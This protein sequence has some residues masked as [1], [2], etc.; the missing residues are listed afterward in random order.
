MRFEKFIYFYPEKPMLIHIEQDLFKRL[1]NDSNMIAEKKYNGQ[2]LELHYLD[3]HFQFWNRHGAE[4]QF[5]PDA[6]LI[7]AL[8]EFASNLK[9]YCIF[10]GELR[11]NK[12]IGVH[13]K[14]VLYDVFMWNGELSTGLTFHQ[15]RS[16][17]RFLKFDSDPRFEFDSGPLIRA[18]FI[19]G[20][21]NQFLEDFNIVIKDPEIEG[22]VIK[23]KRGKLN[24]SRTSNAP[25]NWMW[26]VREKS[27]RYDF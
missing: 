6:A 22:L 14:I 7:F 3:G 5:T 21:Y 9:G 16:V 8:R 13:Q 17:L 10:D 1:D 26:K 15:R 25:S 23:D 27:G 18:S 20:G 19:M 2:R 4:L 12:V 11:H 24:L